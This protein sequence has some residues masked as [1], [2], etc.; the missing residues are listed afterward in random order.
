MTGIKV[1]KERVREDIKY[2][3]E[4]I[5]NRNYDDNFYWYEVIQK[6]IEL[7]LRMISNKV[8]PNEIPKTVAQSIV[9][10][11]AFVHS[12]DYFKV[13]VLYIY[14]CLKDYVELAVKLEEYEAAEN[15]KQLINH[16]K[17]VEPA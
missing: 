11:L 13:I 17:M 8:L 5:N 4:F 3:P 14:G 2:I 12:Q 6:N 16:L 9:T 10:R 7:I 1:L 15:L